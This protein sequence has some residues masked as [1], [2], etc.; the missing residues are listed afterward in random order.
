[1]RVIGVLIGL[2]ERDSDIP[3]RV[4]VFEQ[5]LRELGWVE[6]RN[7]RIHYRFGADSARLRESTRELLS[8][9]PELIVAGSTFVVSAILGETRTIPVVFV[10]ASDPVGDGFVASLAR[11]GGNATGF[12]NSVSSMSGKW[13]ELL[14]EIA[15]GIERVAIMFNPASAPSRGSYFLRP[16][17]TAAASIAI[18]PLPLSM[19]SAADIEPALAALGREPGGGLIAIPETFTVV[20]RGL[21][22]AQ[23]AKQRVP[24]IYPVRRFAADGGLIAYGAD[25]LD[26]YRRTP[27]YVDRILK[28]AKPAE[29]PVQSPA[30]F[31]LV[32][33][34]KTAKALGLAVSP[35]MIARADEVIE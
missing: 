20:N 35:L 34:L 8:L 14:R 23:A 11:P 19:H 16:F 22:I 12:T 21:I 25:L 5:G 15:P 30:K 3:A 31:D 13:L 24:A 10:T 2:S 17:E 18:K 6:G 9:Q 4:S 26:L 29:L 1:L 32:I 7:L 27:S 28:G 33:N